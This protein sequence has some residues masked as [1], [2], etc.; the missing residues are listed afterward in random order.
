METLTLFKD[1]GPVGVLIVGML[2][3]GSLI[4]RQTDAETASNQLIK[5]SDKHLCNKTFDHGMTLPKGLEETVLVLCVILPVIPLVMNKW[6]ENNVEMFKAHITGQTTSY[7]LSELLRHYTVYPESSFLKKCNIS[8]QECKTKRDHITLLSANETDSLCNKKF[9][10]S[11]VQELFD[12]MHHVPNHVCALLGSS[13]V[14]F[15]AILFYWQRL[16]K[17][18]KTPFQTESWLQMFIICLQSVFVFIL[19]YYSYNLYLVLDSIQL[20]GVFFGGIVQV[21]VILSMF[22]NT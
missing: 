18:Q 20:L 12:S 22:K 9:N 16:N 5:V 13:I 21:F 14:S 15:L 2:L 6:T 10:L 4:N 8:S 3:T 11:N 1:H 7:G 17:D 19:A